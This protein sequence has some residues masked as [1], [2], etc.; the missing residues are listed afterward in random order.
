M[1]QNTDTPE[2][3]I[4]REAE[5]ERI[6][7][8]GAERDRASAETDAERTAEPKA[9]EPQGPKVRGRR[10]FGL[11]LAARIAIAV[12]VAAALFGGGVAVGFVSDNGRSGSQFEPGRDGGFDGGDRDG[13]PGPLGND[14]RGDGTGSSDT[15]SSDTESGQ[16]DSSQ[17]D[18]TGS[19]SNSES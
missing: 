7:E 2:S 19:G 5:T 8:A 13:R 16:T 11:P 6:D 12:L 1:V 9:A 17:T 18:S 4:D 15:D 14:P 3:A 10:W